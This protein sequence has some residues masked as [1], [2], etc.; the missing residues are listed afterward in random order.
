MQENAA[1]GTMYCPPILANMDSSGFDDADGVASGSDTA[2]RTAGS[3]VATTLLR[4]DTGAGVGR[5]VDGVRK[6]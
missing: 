2:A 1:F 3:G 4:A 6:L 5:E